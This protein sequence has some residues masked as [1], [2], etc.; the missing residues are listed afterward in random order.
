MWS[1]YKVDNYLLPVA[2]GICDT[3]VNHCEKEAR[4]NLTIGAGLPSWFKVSKDT[5]I[6]ECGM[7]VKAEGF[8]GSFNFRFRSI[9]D[10]FNFIVE[11][12]KD[13]E[14]IFYHFISMIQVYRNK[15]GLGMI[16]LDYIC[17]ITE[18]DSPAVTPGNYAA[19]TDVSIADIQRLLDRKFAGSAFSVMNGKYII[20]VYCENTRNQFFPDKYIPICKK[21]IDDFKSMYFF[22]DAMLFCVRINGKQH[23][24]FCVKSIGLYCNTED[25]SRDF[26][27]RERD[28]L[29]KSLSNMAA[30]FKEYNIT[31]KN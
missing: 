14:H 10:G 7:I 30:G 17:D 22:D 18:A 9:D 23:V 26:L 21:Y 16:D 15:I 3:L 6:N 20:I 29:F 27:E 5:A 8:N 4:V 24:Y 1:V 2:K 19:V 25:E 12:C 11:N 31:I 28:Y 13:T